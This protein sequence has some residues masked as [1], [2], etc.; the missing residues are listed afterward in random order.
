MKL[1]NY[2]HIILAVHYTVYL[3][4][5]M[6]QDVAVH[7]AVYSYGC[8]VD[9]RHLV[10][11]NTSQ[12]LHILVSRALVTLILLHLV[13]VRLCVYFRPLLLI[14][15]W[16]FPCKWL[17]IFLFPYRVF[18]DVIN[19]LQGVFIFIVA[20]CNKD[21]LK[22]VKETLL[23]TFPSLSV[24]ASASKTPPSPPEASLNENL[25]AMSVRAWVGRFFPLHSMWKTAWLW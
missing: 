17:T 2:S 13:F 14:L 6:L 18:T 20:V 25:L 24:R 3:N 21:N 7:Q 4:F 23:K 15:L 10:S 5:T 12:D 19:G 11:C 9:Y 16:L 1:W 22:K 8:G